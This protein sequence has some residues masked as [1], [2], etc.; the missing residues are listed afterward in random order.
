MK[1][2]NRIKI[3]NKIVEVV[4]QDGFVQGKHLGTYDPNMHVITIASELEGRKKLE[5]FLHEVLHSISEIYGLKLT[6][7][8]VEGADLPLTKIVETLLKLNKK[9]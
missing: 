2:P 8:Q 7:R 5:C 1:I 9:E 3:K 6:E 4:Y